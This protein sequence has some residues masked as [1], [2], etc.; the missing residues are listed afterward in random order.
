MEEDEGA[1]MIESERTMGGSEGAFS[2]LHKECRIAQVLNFNKFFS[3]LKSLLIYEH[4]KHRIEPLHL[5]V[6][7]SCL[8][9]CH[10]IQNS[11]HHYFTSLDWLVHPCYNLS[12]KT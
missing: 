9:K 8:I 7:L 5:L 12:L 2:R 1:S 11:D 6:L 10:K 4:D 3:T